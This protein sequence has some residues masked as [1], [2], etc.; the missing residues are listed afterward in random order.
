MA[1]SLMKPRHHLLSGRCFKKQRQPNLPL[2]ASCSLT[3]VSWHPRKP[4]VTL[5]CWPLITDAAHR[6]VNHLLLLNHSYW[7]C[8]I[9]PHHLY[10]QAHWYKWSCSLHTNVCIFCSW[11][12][13][14]CTFGFV[15]FFFV[16]LKERLSFP[17]QITRPASI[18]FRSPFC[19]ENLLHSI[20]NCF[21]FRRYAWK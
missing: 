8:S 1:V 6:C 19:L 17:S 9:C 13:C 20:V 10:P 2:Q 15:F 5:N 16:V 3:A 12:L 11:L 18:A 14:L 4:L 7:C 21:F